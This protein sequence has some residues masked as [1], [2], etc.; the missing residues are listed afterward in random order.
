MG[1]SQ[2]YE[3]DNNDYNFVNNYGYS[4]DDLSELKKSVPDEFAKVEKQITEQKE[5]SKKAAK[6]A[7]EKRRD[8]KLKARSQ[9]RMQLAQLPQRKQHT[10]D[11]RT[12]ARRSS[13]KRSRNRARRDRH[14]SQIRESGASS[15]KAVEERAKAAKKQKEAMSRLTDGLPVHPSRPKHHVHPDLFHLQEEYK[16]VNNA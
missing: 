12:Q 4:M 2:S 6:L 9:A 16:L 8:A 5:E 10:K 1:S 7:V 3:T 15:S 14:L 11:I 13:R